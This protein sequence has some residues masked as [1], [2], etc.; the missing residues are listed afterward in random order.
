MGF[1][2]WRSQRLQG[3]LGPPFT[4]GPRSCDIRRCAR[5]RRVDVCVHCADWPCPRINRLASGY[6]T[7]IADGM[8]LKRIGPD[9]WLEEQ[10][11]RAGTG[12]CYCDI[13]T[14]K[15]ASGKPTGSRSGVGLCG[16]RRTLHHKG[17]RTRRGRPQAR[18]LE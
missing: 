17:A 14:P 1:S 10:E 11:A 18:E 8:R 9:K 16:P 12:F 6:V 13:R 5:K 3:V 2:E 7:L 15:A 4:G